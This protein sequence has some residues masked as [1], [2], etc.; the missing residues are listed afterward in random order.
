MM[1]ISLCCCNI[2]RYEHEFA[3]KFCDFTSF[4]CLDDKHHKIK[5]EEPHCPLAAAE[6]FK[7]VLVG[8]GTSFEVSDHNFSKFSI[9]PSVSLLVDIS[10]DISGSWYHSQ[11]N[12]SLKEGAYEPSSPLRHSSELSNFMTIHNL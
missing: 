6:H 5:I 1:Y 8:D 4:V 11:A 10:S 7:R 2:S 12:V 9:V 3:V